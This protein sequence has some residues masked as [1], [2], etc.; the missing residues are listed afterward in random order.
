MTD[1]DRLIALRRDISPSNAMR[2]R[3]RYSRTRPGYWL[4]NALAFD[5]HRKPPWYAVASFRYSET[6]RS[7]AEW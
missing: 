7:N 3:N 5:W 1:A 2:E 6:L 4:N